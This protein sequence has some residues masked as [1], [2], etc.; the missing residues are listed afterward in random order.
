M[1]TCSI[2]GVTRP[3]CEF[4]NRKDSPDGK[5]GFCK[6]CSKKNKRAWR[7]ANPHKAAAYSRRFRER[8]LEHVRAYHRAYWHAKIKTDPIKR[9]NSNVSAMVYHSLRH[10][11]GKRH[12]RWET[13]VGYT[14]EELVAHLQAKFLPGMTWENYGAWHVDHI[15]PLSKSQITS[16]ESKEFRAAWALSNLQPLWAFDNVSK[17]ARI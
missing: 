9:L 8:N 16:A 1:K 17:G 5:Y 3:L 4:G 13:L 10:A 11:G 15:F 12:R 14:T 2:C 6:E 7:E